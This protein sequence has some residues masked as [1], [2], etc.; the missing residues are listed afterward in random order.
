MKMFPWVVS[1]CI[2]ARDQQLSYCPG[3]PGGQP[4][5]HDAQNLLRIATR[6]STH[7]QPFQYFQQEL[8]R[9]ITSLTF[10]IRPGR[11]AT[12]GTLFFDKLL[13]RC[14]LHDGNSYSWTGLQL[15]WMIKTAV[16]CFELLAFKNPSF[17]LCTLF[18]SC[19]LLI[20][21]VTNIW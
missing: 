4:A 13:H 15:V 14:H 5:S 21:Y 9:K 19:K 2:Q 1:W 6:P 7:R 20:V 8:G 11:K 16:N 17:W 3:L 12:L 10:T 18:C